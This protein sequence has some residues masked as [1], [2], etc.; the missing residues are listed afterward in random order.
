MNSR[1]FRFGVV[2]TPSSDGRQWQSVARRTADQ[3][4]ST[5]LM[6]DGL[7]LLA[8]GPA[9]ASAAAVADIRVGTWVYAA[10]LRPPRAT[11][12]EAHT[13]DVLTDGRFEMGIG[14][15]RPAVEESTELL[16]LPY[17]SPAARL[18]QVRATVTALREL[19]GPDR[20][21]PVLI[22]AGGPSARRLAA[23]LADSV[24]LAISP[25][26]TSARILDMIRDLRDHAGERADTIELAMNL[27][28]VGED[29]PPNLQ[30]V[31]GVDT[32]TLAAHDSLVML[33]GDPAAMADELQ[34]RRDRYGFSYVTVNAAFADRLAP[35]VDLL[36]G[37]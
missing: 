10:P 34:R 2:A 32:A 4:Y 17:G 29:V 19:D 22:A 7:Q 16:N 35:V 13:L 9:L 30:Q 1:P 5:L 6:P 24:T 26:E 11:A 12:W 21:T 15:G 20:H 23:E 25:L 31:I 8:P 28:V 37:H 36:T 14:A 18:A 27:F 3:G 33:R